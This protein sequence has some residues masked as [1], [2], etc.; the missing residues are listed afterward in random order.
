MASGSAVQASGLLGRLLEA[1]EQGG[2]GGSMIGIL[3]LQALACQM[4]GDMRAAL[5]PLERALMLAEPEGYVR[6][7][8]TKGRLWL[9]RSRQRRKAGSLQAMCSGS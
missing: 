5:V 3:L 2:T 6:V 1:A 9:P 4:R 8:S 7:L